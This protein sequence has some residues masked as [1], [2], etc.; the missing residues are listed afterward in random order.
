MTTVRKIAPGDQRGWSAG[1]RWQMLLLIAAMLFIHSQV[2]AIRP[3]YAVR[4]ALFDYYQWL[5]PRPREEAPVVIVAIDEKGLRQE[6]Q[7]PWPR[8]RV[9]ALI[10]AIMAA[11]PLALGIDISFA[12]A[13]RLGPASLAQ[14]Y[15]QIPEPLWRTL[16]DPDNAL[17]QAIGS[18]PVVLGVFALS[19]RLGEEIY[20]PT[21]KHWLLQQH[22]GVEANRLTG[23]YVSSLPNLPQLE[24]A[25]AGFGLLNTTADPNAY[26]LEHGVVRRVPLLTSI[27]RETLPILGLEMLRVALDYP[28]VEVSS[29]TLP[30]FHG[31]ARVAVGTYGADTDERG[32]VRL[33][34]GRYREGYDDRYVSAADL[35]SGRFDINQLQ[36]RFVL[37]GFNALGLNDMVTT[38]LGEYVPGVDVHAQLIE[39]VLSQS[40]LHRPYWMPWFESLWLLLWVL[41]S[42]VLAQRLHARYITLLGLCGIA[43]LIAVG[44]AAFRLRGWLFDIA[45]LGLL[46]TPLYVW[47]FRE[48]MAVAEQAREQARQLLQSTRENNARIDGELNAA[49]RIQF[50]LLPDPEPLTRNDKRFDLGV[51]LE[52]AKEISGDYYDCFI[53]E[54]RYLVLAIGDVSGKGVPA[55]LFM[56]MAKTLSATHISQ[57]LDDPGLALQRVEQELNRNN[58]ESLFV[59]SLLAVCDL[60]SGVLTLANA[61]HDD[62]LRFRPAAG[63]GMVL[64]PA[65]SDSYSGPPLCTLGDYPFASGTIQ[66]AAGEGLLAFTDGISEAMYRDPTV[67]GAVPEAYGRGRIE[68]TLAATPADARAG[69]VATRL[70]ADVVD[71]TKGQE[72]ADDATVLVL[73]WYGKTA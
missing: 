15:R 35:M 36:G 51:R 8:T 49:R 62:P 54:Q 20:A 72:A 25:A 19:E 44:V 53:V 52:S 22:G 13:D 10:S 34:F 55:S 21:M 66:L 39:G 70:Y 63:G 32:G 42:V 33:Y 69:E 64:T 50:G 7:W 1:S 45:V 16:P 57:H 37:I 56:S 30:G 38:P 68:K 6:G 18:G 48:R 3:L 12:E 67:A 40:V 31:I 2:E 27:G 23:A 17:A 4:Q 11:K 43:C 65:A 41:P 61:G 29:L 47:L 5:W 28:A 59:T 9:A 24:Q 73:I 58:P 14:R 26:S 46:L 71:F 60:E